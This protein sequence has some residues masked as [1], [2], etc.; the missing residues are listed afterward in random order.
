M[1][2]C[3]KRESF[4]ILSARVVGEGGMGVGGDDIRDEI[5]RHGA[6]W[7]HRTFVA[8]IG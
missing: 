5:E 3:S 2:C 1:R 8:R 7:T 4:S 6:F